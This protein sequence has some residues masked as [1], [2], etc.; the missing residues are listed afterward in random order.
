MSHKILWENLEI[1]SNKQLAIQ[2]DYSY[3]FSKEKDRIQ[4]DMLNNEI[5][6]LVC[7]LNCLA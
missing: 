2:L 3:W 1:A 6:N 7:G 5:K 4:S